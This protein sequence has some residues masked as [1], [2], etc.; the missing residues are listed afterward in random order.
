M[1]P[2]DSEALLAR[3]RQL[4]ERTNPPPLTDELLEQARNERRDQPGCGG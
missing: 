1:S 4:R 2:I 3:I